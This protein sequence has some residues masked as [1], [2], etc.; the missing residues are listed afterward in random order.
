M[1][2]LNNRRI[3]RFFHL[4]VWCKLLAGS[5][6]FFPLPL[7]DTN[8]KGTLDS[9]LLE[10]GQCHHS[11]VLFDGSHPWWYPTSWQVT[12]W[13]CCRI[14]RSV[15]PRVCTYPYVQVLA[16][17]SCACL[18]I[19]QAT[20]EASVISRTPSTLFCCPVPWLCVF[21]G[22]IRHGWWQQFVRPHCFLPHSTLPTRGL[23]VFLGLRF[24][25][26][27]AASHQMWPLDPGST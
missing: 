15:D 19:L 8:T 24:Q 4:L 1:Y 16:H 3:F 17:G 10:G 23:S 14:Y 27:M 21:T 13:H 22:V 18:S 9:F 2:S 6:F 25:D 11:L 5:C 26:R 20:R 7:G 12:E